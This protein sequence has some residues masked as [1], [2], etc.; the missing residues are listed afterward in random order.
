MKNENIKVSIITVCYNSEKTIQDTIDSIIAQTYKNIEYIIVDG[1]SNDKTMEII[2]KNEKNIKK[3]VKELKIISEKDEGLWDAMDKGIKLST[4][5]II[6]II[7]SDDWYEKETIEKV[8]TKY[9][10]EKYDMVYGNLRIINGKKSFIKKAKL[11]KLYST[12]YWNHPTTFIKREIYNEFKY[13]DKLCPDLD[14]ML[15]MRKN[16]K[17]V[18]INEILANFRYGGMST[19]LSIKELLECLKK[20]LLTYKI[21]NCGTIFN[22]LDG[23]IVEIV[24]YIYSRI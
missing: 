2:K 11:K 13:N 24:K 1:K 12:R 7:N 15:K 17:V 9:I 4:G 10:L 16:K 20:R 6:G 19:S 3:N 8:V 5:E 14:L 22:Y 23:V 18:I 21:N